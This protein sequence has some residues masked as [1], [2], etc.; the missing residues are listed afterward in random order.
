MSED[1]AE[2]QL[3]KVSVPSIGETFPKIKVTTTQGAISLPDHFAG[4]W[5]LFFTHPGDFT[6]VCTTEFASMALNHDKFRQLNC[7]LIGLSI[8]SFFSHVK[9][10]EWIKDK[11]GVEVDFPIIADPYGKVATLLGAIHPA[12]GDG[13]IRAVYVIDPQAKIRAITFYPKGIGRNVEELLRT[14]E[15]L[16]VSEKANAVIPANWPHNE[17]IGD[18]VL[19]RPPH[20]IKKAMELKEKMKDAE[21]YDWWFCHRKA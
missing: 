6:P 14:V 12:A 11:L 21:C 20:D 2:H 10:V 15:A 7:E 19:V 5:F 3:Q 4:K 17:F 9:W 8:D 16:Q 13:A 1:V 18:H